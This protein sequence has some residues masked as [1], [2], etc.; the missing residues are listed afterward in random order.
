MKIWPGFFVGAIFILSIA[1]YGQRP[2]QGS[3]PPASGIGGGIGGSGFKPT[4][5]LSNSSNPS[6]ATLSRCNC[7]PLDAVSESDPE[8]AKREK[9][10]AYFAAM[11]RKRNIADTEKLVAL[12][13]ELTSATEGT[14]GNLPTAG[15]LKRVEAIEKLARRVM[16]RMGIQQ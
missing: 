11:D 10:A 9:L 4:N 15:D 5:M 2:V 14:N 6:P 16:D 13:R 12:A 8:A 1:A 3:A 7:S